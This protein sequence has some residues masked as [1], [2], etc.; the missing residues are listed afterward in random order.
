[1]FWFRPSAMPTM[2]ELGIAETDFEVELGQVDG[3]LAHALERLFAFGV[4]SRKYKV[5]EMSFREA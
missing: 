5:D 4:A 1:M 2:A 3:T